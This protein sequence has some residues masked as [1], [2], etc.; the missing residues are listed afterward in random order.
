MGSGGPFD[1]FLLF[2]AFTQKE[3]KVGIRHLLVHPFTPTIW[4]LNFLDG[5]GAY[6]LDI[7]VPND[8]LLPGTTV[9]HQ[10]LTYD[11]MIKEI[12]NLSSTEIL[13]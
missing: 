6:T 10:F 8:P 11:T 9:Y 5:Q 13:Q 2:F 7:Q 3:A 4:F 1:P 12:S